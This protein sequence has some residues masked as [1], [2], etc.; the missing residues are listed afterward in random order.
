MPRS[1]HMCF[2]SMSAWVK[3]CLVLDKMNW[4]WSQHQ[5]ISSLISS[6]SLSFFVDL[7]SLANTSWLWC[8]STSTLV[9][10][11]MSFQWPL[12]G[13][14]LSVF[15][16]RGCI[17]FCLGKIAYLPLAQQTQIVQCPQK[18]QTAHIEPYVFSWQTSSLLMD[19]SNLACGNTCYIR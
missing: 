10:C 15:Y 3:S 12:V 18:R 16:P 4:S 11:A 19:I 9:L 13:K 7:D 1:P 2:S 6:E 8:C 17:W 5:R 14:P